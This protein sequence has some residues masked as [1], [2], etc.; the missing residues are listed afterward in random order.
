MHQIM[1]T[2]TH[3]HEGGPVGRAALGGGGVPD[4]FGFQ[5]GR[6]AVQ[7]R[8]GGPV[9]GG[10]GAVGALEVVGGG[11]CQLY[12]EG[13]AGAGQVDGVDV[14][15]GGEPGGDLGDPAGED[16]DHPAGDVG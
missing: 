2:S 9:V 11:Y 16:I 3:D 15:V 5:V 8:G 7:G 10:A 12:S 4:G 1:V 13:V 6:Q 14:H